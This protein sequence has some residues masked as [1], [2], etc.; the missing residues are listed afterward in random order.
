MSG[1]TVERTLTVKMKGTLE[2]INSFCQ[3]IGEA[4]NEYDLDVEF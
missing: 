3:R 2:E 1:E 4:A